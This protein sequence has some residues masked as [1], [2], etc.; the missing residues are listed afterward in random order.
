[1]DVPG[2][3]T[4][5]S[6]IVVEHPGAV[7]VLAVDDQERALVVHQYRH[8]A[9]VRFVE[10]P[11]GLLDEPGEDPLGAARRELREEVGV[12]AW[13]WSPLLRFYTSP[14]Y[15]DERI[16][17]F[18]ARDL[19]PLPERGGF[20]PEHEEADMTVHRVPVADLVAGV[21]DGEL[22]D[23]PLATAVLTYALLRGVASTGAGPDRV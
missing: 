23:G 15:S 21:L 4:T 7:V 22:A 11:A 5:A 20:Q 10:L 9:G 17:V 8:A 16:V 19:T 1:M 18:L 3:G 12:E 6:R 14:G 2:Q 13:D